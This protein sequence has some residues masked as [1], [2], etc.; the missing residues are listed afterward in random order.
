MNV[1][2]VPIQDGRATPAHHY[3]KPVS[4]WLRKAWK[5]T[6]RETKAEG[7]QWPLWV[8]GRPCLSLLSCLPA[9]PVIAL[10]QK[11][12]AP[13]VGE[14]Q[15]SSGGRDPCPTPSRPW[16]ALSWPQGT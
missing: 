11:P 15:G 5:R 14:G 13:E 12:G 3:S 1:V 8:G 4:Y 10:S 9:G 6:V 16:G 2:P 7:R